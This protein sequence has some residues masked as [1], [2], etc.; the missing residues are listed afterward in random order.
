MLAVA[1]ALAALVQTV[2]A[3]TG[4]M[5]NPM[6]V[7]PAPAA[8]ETPA[9]AEAVAPTTTA[10]PQQPRMICRNEQVTGTRFPIR[11]CRSAVQTEAERAEGRDM[12]R[13]M[14]GARTPPQG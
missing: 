2:P 3:Q 14:Q 1:L 4:G 8:N 12:L 10:E 9:A 7:M 5:T 13:R 6:P 11:R